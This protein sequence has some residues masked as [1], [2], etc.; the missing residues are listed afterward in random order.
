MKYGK[1]SS[2]NS[3]VMETEWRGNLYMGRP[4]EWNWNMGKGE[5]KER[6]EEEKTETEEDMAI[7]ERGNRTAG[8]KFDVRKGKWSMGE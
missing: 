5:E 8:R 6:G 7:E 4:W 2:G 3:E 1:K